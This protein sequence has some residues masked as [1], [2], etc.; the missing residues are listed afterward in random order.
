MLETEQIAARL[1]CWSGPVRPV[2]LAGGISNDSFLVED[3]AGKYVVRVNGDV[4]V[5]GVWRAND[6]ACNRA[7]AAAGVAPAVHYAGARAVVVDY[8]EGRTL[9]AEDVRIQANLAKIL[10]L[11]QRTHVDAYRHLRGPVCGFWPFRVC[12]DYANFLDEQG[13][14]MAPEIVRLRAANERLEN[15]AGPVSIVLGHNDLLA[16]NFIDDGTRIWLIDWEHAGLTSPLF[17]LA[18]LASNNS[19]PQAREVWLLEAYFGQP[20]GEELQRRFLA[21][22]CASLLREAM[23][24]MV[25]EYTS[26]LDFD[27][28]AYSR[29][30]LGRFEVEYDRL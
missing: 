21:M 25:S 13:G 22:K 20:A 27:Y 10:P 12:R 2:R 17:D 14:R 15:I 16:A 24:S 18:N 1:P 3:G 4:P 26:A 19:L 9:G 5:H 30:F 28:A 29:D 6:A 7:A 23:W 8:I 11:I